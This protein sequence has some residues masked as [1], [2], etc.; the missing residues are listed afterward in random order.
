VAIKEAIVAADPREAGRRQI[1]NFG[2]T[3]GHAVEARSGY[4]FAHGEAV[5]I[6]MATEA[7]LAE[8]LG[9]ADTGLA[10]AVRGA[11]ERFGLPVTIPADLAADDLVDAMQGDKKVR[12]GSV[13]FALP[14]RIG[15]MTQRDDGAWTVEVGR[16]A[17]LQM[18]AASR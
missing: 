11:L 9:V 8:S 17:I 4:A 18:L 15:E 13:R 5:A 16:D 7:L 3:V 12:A 2:H 14:R 6:G 1:L 10:T